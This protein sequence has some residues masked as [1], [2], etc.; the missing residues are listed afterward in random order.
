MSTDV[1]VYP[2]TATRSKL[3]KRPAIFALGRDRKLGGR[4]IELG[5]YVLFKLRENYAGHV[6]GG[7]AKTWVAETTGLTHADAVK[8]INKRL[9]FD[10]FTFE[11]PKATKKPSELDRE[12][13]EIIAK[14]KP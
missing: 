10:A 5:G 13:D 1:S 12:V 4:P 2:K 14:A 8:L 3:G 6:R 7:I 11:G 9:G